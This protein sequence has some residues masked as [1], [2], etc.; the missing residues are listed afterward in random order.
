MKEVSNII[1]SNFGQDRLELSQNIIKTAQKQKINIVNV[2][3][4]SYKNSAWGSSAK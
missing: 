2:T 3:V 4:N 1:S